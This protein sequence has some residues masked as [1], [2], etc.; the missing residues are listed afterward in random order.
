MARKRSRWDVA[1]FRKIKVLASMPEIVRKRMK[2]LLQKNAQRIVRLQQAVAPRPGANPYATGDLRDSIT[3]SFGSRPNFT[4]KRSQTLANDRVAGDKDLSVWVYAADFKGRWVEF[5]TAPRGD[6]PGTPAMP[7]FYPAIR[8]LRKDV[9]RSV[10]RGWATA[11]KR[12]GIPGYKPRGRNVR[13]VVVG[14]LN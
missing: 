13:P 14:G 8:F 10:Q 4:R 5:G 11:L 2:P 9:R 12:A 6:H 1:R 3:F 7:F